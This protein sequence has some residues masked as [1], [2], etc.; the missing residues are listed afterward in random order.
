MF[1][2]S[3]NLSREFATP[4]LSL[5]E[6]YNNNPTSPTAGIDFKPDT[7]HNAKIKIIAATKLLESPIR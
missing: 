5:E 1:L 6:I 4:C 2:D 7:D 3:C